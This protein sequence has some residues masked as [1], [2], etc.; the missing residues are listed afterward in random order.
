MNIFSR[1]IAYPILERELLNRLADRDAEI[2]NLR[3]RISDLED[4]LFMVRGVPPKGAEIPTGKAAY[5]PTYRT[6]RQRLRDMVKQPVVET[7]S[8]EEEAQIRDS[9]TQ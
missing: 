7:L 4:R 9:L 5:I 8:E 3:T 2:V 6:G 1:G